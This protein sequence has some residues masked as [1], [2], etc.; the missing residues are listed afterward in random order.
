[1]LQDQ[2]G[3]ALSTLSTEAAASFDRTVLAYLKY[4]ADTP[5]QLARTLAADPKFGLAYCLAWLLRDA[6]VQAGQRPDA[7]AAARTARALTRRLLHGNGLTWRHW[8]RGS[9]AHPTHPDN[10]GRHCH[11]PSA[12]RGCLPPGPFEQFL[13]WPTRG[14]MRASGEGSVVAG[15]LPCH[16]LGTE[17]FLTLRLYAA[18]KIRL[19]IAVR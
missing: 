16:H 10:L 13:A 7:A 3:L 4:R 17:Y 9:Q 19:G 1:M 5:Q 6:L 2:H 8:M 12:G 14:A 18:P 15:K 11:R